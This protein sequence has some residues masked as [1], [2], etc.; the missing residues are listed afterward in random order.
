MELARRA[1]PGV[2]DD[3]VDRP[4]RVGD[5]LDDGGNTFG[6]RE[7]RGEDL[8]ALVSIGEL[9]QPLDTPGH[10]HLRDA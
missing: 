7:V 9:L 4:L 2:V 10:H 5:S 1:E 3:E 8:D 6:L